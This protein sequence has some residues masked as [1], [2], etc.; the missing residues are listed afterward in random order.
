[1]RRTLTVLGFVSLI[2]LGVCVSAKGHSPQEK[3]DYTQTMAKETLAS[4]Y[5]EAPEAEKKVQNAAGYGCFSNIDAKL[6]FV[7][8]GDGFGMVHNDDTGKDTYMK[9][10]EI[11][12]GLG[13]E[14]REFR[15]LIIFH[16]E[17]TLNTFVNSGWEWGAEA[18]AAAKA[19]DA[20][21]GAD[22]VENVFGGMEV[23]QITEDGVAL[24]ATISGT[25]YWR[26]DDLN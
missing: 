26:D 24:T 8:T 18:D 6:F 17:D 4:V 9:M 15:A 2:A 5:K 10:R 1:M 16:D 7:T 23:Y 19:D 3:R 22:V 14:L 20:G 13:Y 12:V 25:K 11:G 21:L